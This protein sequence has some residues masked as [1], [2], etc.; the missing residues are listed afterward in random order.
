MG[1]FFFNWQ[2]FLPEDVKVFNTDNRM[3]TKTFAIL[4]THFFVDFKHKKYT[5][6]ENRR[7]VVEPP[8]PQ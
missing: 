1:C 7:I 4:Q 2:K 8:R 5:M 3:C 6:S